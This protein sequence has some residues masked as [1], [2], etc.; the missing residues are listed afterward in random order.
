M[1]PACVRDDAV[2][3]A[4]AIYEPRLRRRHFKCTAGSLASREKKMHFTLL[5]PDLANLTCTR[6]LAG[7]DT[8]EVIEDTMTH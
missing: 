3:P 4:A 2:W 1:L 8:S 7:S 5:T 6:N